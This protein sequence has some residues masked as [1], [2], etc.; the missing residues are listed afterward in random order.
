[1]I[2]C[3]FSTRNL[4]LPRSTIFY[5][6][7]ITD[8]ENLRWKTNSSIFYSRQRIRFQAWNDKGGII[9]KR[10]FKYR[11]KYIERINVNLRRELNS[12]VK[13]GR[14]TGSGRHPRGF[15]STGNVL[16]PKLV[17]D[18]LPIIYYTFCMSKMSRGAMKRSILEIQILRWCRGNSDGIFW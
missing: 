3:T 8:K 2:R 6:K 4:C 12:G 17:V 16:F 14:S 11:K 7:Q 9:I 18:I 13:H 5:Q 1:M 15:N 10:K